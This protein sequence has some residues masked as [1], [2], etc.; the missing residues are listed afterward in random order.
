MIPILALWLTLTGVD[1]QLTALSV[2]P[3]G[4]RTEV[5]I[6]ID[7]SV[8]TRDFTL[9]DP[10]RLVVDISGA[11][12]DATLDSPVGRGGVKRIRIAQWQPNIVRVVLDLTAAVHYQVQQE[13]GTVRISFPNPSTAFEPWNS[14]L[15]TTRNGADSADAVAQG[16]APPPATGSS[17]PA[18]QPQQ[19][20]PLPPMTVTF[21]EVPVA[22]VLAAFAEY[23]D[24]SIIA[25][26]D[27]KA[28][29][30]TA[31]IRDQPWSVALDAILEANGMRKRE[32]A[33]GVIIVE[34][35]SKVVERQSTEPLISRQYRIQYV[36]ADSLLQAVT[37]LLSDKGKAS[38]NSASNSLLVTD[39]RA[40]LER[41]EPIIKELDVRTP[42]VSISAT[43]A[44]I[45]RTAL[46]QMGVQYDLKDSRGNQLNKLVSGYQDTNGNGVYEPDEATKENVVL[47][48]GSSIA[49]LANANYP[50]PSPALELVTSLVLGRHTLVSFLQALQTVSLSDV[51]AKPTVQVMDNREA[52][53]QVGEDTPI[54]I[55]D[56]GAATGAAGGAGAAGGPR[57]TVSFKNTGIILRVTPHITGDQ[58]LLDMHAERSSATPVSS[59]IGFVFNTQNADT[60]VLVDDGETAVVGGLTIIEKTRT[61]TGIPL[62]MDLPV[63]G[64]LFRNTLDQ[65]HKRDL[66]IMVTPHIIRN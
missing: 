20:Q 36:S 50:V 52:R 22:D 17:Q 41:I 39:N 30:I 62:L 53:I 64:K 2:S 63:L 60:Q 54:R 12:L 23:A 18:P 55:I 14:T 42:Q 35:A 15:P 9:V 58:V 4:D 33:S 10:D 66:L 65:E 57:A 51:Q 59:D 7:G 11:H 16:A 24:R 34:D 40:V 6:S 46:E 31:E 48:G 27:V 26:P 3:V 29:V 61:R 37:S 21:T 44:F 45:D 38:A 8:E 28:K 49:A 1:S 19:Q 47:L 32:L 43:I 56:A 5:A 25:S 13:A